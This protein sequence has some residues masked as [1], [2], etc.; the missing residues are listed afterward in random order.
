MQM[1]P[2]E[3]S[4]LRL[5]DAA[6]EEDLRD[7]GDVTCEYFVPDSSTSE[8]NINARVDGVLAGIEIAETV[9]QK[10]DPKMEFNTLKQSGDRLSEGDIV[11]EIS[12]STRSILTAERTALNFLQRMSGVASLTRQFVDKV[13]NHKAKILDTRKTLP[14]WRVLDKAA[15]K[16]GGGKN[17]RMGLY[18]MAMV[19]DNHLL[20]GGHLT[21][22]DLQRS[23]DQLR[24]EC[25]EV[26][27]EL[28]ADRMSRV[29]EFLA[30]EGVDYIM[31]D[32]MSL[33]QLCEAV[34]MRDVSESKV[35]LEASGGVNLD[36][37][38]EIAATG[39]D[40]ISVGALTHSA[41]ALDLALD[42][43]ES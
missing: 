23:I 28:E 27:I 21:K 43:D 37:V 6:L 13:G 41:V 30:L 31:L 14:G 3:E 1:A 18:D 22:D 10:V 9:F 2:L 40:Y 20:A 42:L 32:N 12:G 26:K 29:E 33:E 8:G 24:E 35:E 7:V 4:V 34:A 17:H 25:P 11:M 16:A 39:V 36:T 15:V 5:I 19:K 38:E